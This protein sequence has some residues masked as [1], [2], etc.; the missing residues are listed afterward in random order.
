MTNYFLVSLLLFGCIQF[1]FNLQQDNE[2]DHQRNHIEAFQR[3]HFTKSHSQERIK[4]AVKNVLIKD[5]MTVAQ[6]A[7]RRGSS[8]RDDDA[9]HAVS[10][11]QVEGGQKQQ[12]QQQQEEEEEEEREFDYREQDLDKHYLAGLSCERFGGPSDEDAAEMIF[13]EDIPSDSLHVSPF[14]DPNRKQ[15]LTFE[16]DHGAYHWVV[17]FLPLLIIV[18]HGRRN[19]ERACTL[20]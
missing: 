12:K 7:R 6:G 1:Y 5:I 16:A 18:E 11:A 4:A 17:S 2:I 3:K 9:K 15:Y 14:Q 19:Y 13:W 20:I 10:G 8:T